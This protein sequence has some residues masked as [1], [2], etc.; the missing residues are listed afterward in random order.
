MESATLSKP[1]NRFADCIANSKRICW[2]IDRD[3]IRGRQFELDH[4]FLPDSLSRVDRLQFLTA[5]DQRLLSQVQGRTYANMFGLVERFIGAK[6]LELSRAH[7]LGD[8]VALEALVRFTGEELK[9]QELFRRIDGLMEAV[10]PAGYRFEHD[11]NQVAEAV[12]ASHDWAVLA[13]TCHIELFTQAHYLKSLDSGPELSEIFRDVF[14]FHWKE[15]SQHA[16]LDELEW[17]RTHAV[18][19]GSEV[20]AALEQLIQLVYTVDGMLQAQAESDRRYFLSIS[21]AELGMAQSVQLGAV[22]LQAYRWQYLVSGFLN[23]R[24]YGLLAEL[25]SPAQLAR[26]QAATLP[27]INATAE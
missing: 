26:I 3:V 16:V 1:R 21:S 18:M 19:S 5:P 22:L 27:L 6:M 4:K 25:L 13:L 8:Q 23:A 7:S 12:L 14:R 17:R 9:H 11:P 15:E 24:F 10:M 2:D 20:D